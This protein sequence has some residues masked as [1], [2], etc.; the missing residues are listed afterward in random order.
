M[1]NKTL[2]WQ[3]LSMFV[4]FIGFYGN[5]LGEGGQKW[6][7][8]ISFSITALLNSKILSSGSWPTGWSVAMWATQIVG[9]L[10]QIANFMVEK[11]LIDPQ[12]VNIVI[13]A[14]NTFLVTFVKDYGS[15]SVAVDFGSKKS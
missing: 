7:G 14:I 10:I 13:M 8:V 1:K 4:V 5:S 6:I 2:L 3:I 12:V 11:A 9:L 15:G